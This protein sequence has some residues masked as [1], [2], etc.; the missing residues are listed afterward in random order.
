MKD[1]FLEKILK[2]QDKK[3]PYIS[4]KLTEDEE[5]QKVIN[6]T[7]RHFGRLDYIINNAGFNDGVDIN[8]SLQNSC[9]QCMIIYFILQ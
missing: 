9:N 1:L 7:V 8:R 3:T 5:C 6:K 2:D 4:A